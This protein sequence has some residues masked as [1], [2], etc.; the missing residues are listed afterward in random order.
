M[1]KLRNSSSKII[2]KF[3]IFLLAAALIG[4]IQ[5]QVKTKGKPSPPKPCNSNG[6]CEWDEVNRNGD[7]QWCADCSPKQ[8]SP[9]NL[10]PGPQIVAEGMVDFSYS[11]YRIFQFVGEDA[12]QDGIGE[13]HD[14]WACPPFE[15][16]SN[17]TVPIATIGDAD[18]DGQKEIVA[19]MRFFAY[20]V[21]NGKNA[22][23][24]YHS[25]IFLFEHG[26]SGETAWESPFFDPSPAGP[27]D[28][29]IGDVDGDGSNE[30]VILKGN[31]LSICEVHRVGSG[32]EF[33]EEY[34]GVFPTYEQT[35][36]S[37]SLGDANNDGYE[38]IILAMFFVGAPIVWSY[39]GSA[40]TSTTGEP[41][42]PEYWN[43]DIN[44]P[45]LG[46]DTAIARDADNMPG[47]EIIAGGNNNRLMIW[48]YNLLSSSYEIKFISEDIGGITQGFE[49]GDID[50]QS[51][52]EIIVGDQPRFRDPALHIFKFGVSTYS[53][54]YSQT[55]AHSILSMEIGDVDNDGAPE[56]V[57]GSVGTKIYEFVGGQ[58]IQSYACVWGGDPRIN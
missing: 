53:E 2:L 16:T 55:I 45:F 41:I 52:N 24:Y 31:H 15:K 54:V 25:K 32:Y 26:S 57:V 3:A 22:I 28:I 46:I 10:A 39:D 19:A 30:I 35:V 27:K 23:N 37:I 7:N 47:N 38:D 40:W 58:F 6:Q 21:G 48:K 12:N 50:G 9:L 5:A 17:S 13:Y 1:G 42:A 51:G 56:I 29:E 14:A 33:I 8:Y 34:V 4:S 44:P 18:N 49:V 43:P 20:K 11:V 36:Y